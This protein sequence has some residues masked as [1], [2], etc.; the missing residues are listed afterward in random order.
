MIDDP[1]DTRHSLRSAPNFRDIGGVR[2][3]DGRHVWRE[4]LFRSEMIQAPGEADADVLKRCGIEIVFDLRSAS[5]A[6][7]RPHRYWVDNGVEI[8]AFDVGTDVRAKGSFW[9]R[10]KDDGGPEATL[11]LLQAV[12]RSIPVAVAP[13]LASMFAALSERPVPILFH[14][15][16]GKDRTGVTAALLYAALGVGRETIMVDYL[17]TAERLTP[18]W[19]TAAKHSFLDA[20]GFPLPEE[21]LDLLVGV[22]QRLLEQ[23]F[24]Y[25]DRKFGG[26][27]PFLE[28]HAG[29]STDVR[30]RMQRHLLVDDQ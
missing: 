2:T 21:S 6:R 3:E 22:D 24:A 4:R 28:Q 20:M 10:L 30:R 26:V 16:A 29:L 25:L 8:R 7:S 13:A 18:K 14:C 11:A 17:A 15:A 23:S 9:E 5:E 12:Y 19:I 27:A 1:G